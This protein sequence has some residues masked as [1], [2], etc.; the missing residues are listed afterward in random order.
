MYPKNE[1]P[2][3]TEQSVPTNLSSLTTT[4]DLASMRL[5]QDFHATLGVKKLTTTVPVRKPNRQEFFRVHP[6]WMFQ[7][8][9][10][11]LKEENE[12]YLVGR[13]L[14]DELIGE[15]TPRAIFAVMNRQGVFFLW[16]ARLPRDD[17]RKDA[18]AGSALNAA[19]KAKT[20]WIRLV[21]NMSLGAYDIFQAPSTLAD[22]VW[23]EEKFEQLLDLAFKDMLIKDMSHPVVRRLRGE[24]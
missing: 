10:L 9:V 23:P 8:Q 6:D 13:P 5:S 11:E 20:H 16:P 2:A 7:T 1:G 3:A 19:S 21:A 22:P 18:W 14:W 24:V 17:G 12:T 4:L 15:L